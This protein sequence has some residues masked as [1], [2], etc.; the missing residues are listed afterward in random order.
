MREREREREREIILGTHGLQ[1]VGNFVI[2]EQMCPTRV[3][4]TETVTYFGA[5]W[6]AIVPGALCVS[7]L[8]WIGVR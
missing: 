1:P 4:K 8:I 2:H 3:V 6:G 7:I 5:D